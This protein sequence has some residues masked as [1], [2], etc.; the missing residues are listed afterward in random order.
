[1]K[2]ARKAEARWPP[3]AVLIRKK[4]KGGR[5]NVA[6]ITEIISSGIYSLQRVWNIHF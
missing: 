2:A 5:E 3:Y 1:M 6:D 4:N